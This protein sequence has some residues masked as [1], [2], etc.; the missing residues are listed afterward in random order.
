M[1]DIEKISYDDYEI[2]KNEEH[3]PTGKVSFPEFGDMFDFY[4]VVVRFSLEEIVKKQRDFEVLGQYLD[5]NL[6]LSAPHHFLGFLR[7][8]YQPFFNRNL[9]TENTGIPRKYNL[10]IQYKIAQYVNEWVKSK[11]VELGLQDDFES[12][13]IISLPIFSSM[14]R[15]IIQS[16]DRSKRDN[17]VDRLTAY[18]N[19]EPMPLIISDDETKQSPPLE[20]EVKKDLLFRQVALLYVYDGLLLNEANCYE[21]AKN[22]GL[23]SGKTLMKHYRRFRD[24]ETNRRNG[25]T[26]RQD[27]EI[28]IPLLTTEK[29]RDWANEDFKNTKI[30]FE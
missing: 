19:N 21:E 30:P 23:A 4:E 14:Y 11:I 20:E 13:Y 8:A 10:S 17:F 1:Q 2:L 9:S 5:Y 3:S 25:E 16:Y 28:I 24:S 12:N 22:H 29:G 7:F 6:Y 15:D 27:L 18:M 26:S